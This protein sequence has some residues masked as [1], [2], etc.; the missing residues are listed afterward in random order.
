MLS[1]FRSEALFGHP[2]QDEWC[3]G[4]PADSLTVDNICRVCEI[5]DADN[6]FTLNEIVERMLPVGCEW[7][8]IHAIIRN[9][10]AL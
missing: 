5:L 2:V 9:V 7:S 6:C 4:Q 1:I 3:D 8:T 10:L